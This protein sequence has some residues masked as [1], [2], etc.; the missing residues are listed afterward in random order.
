[1]SKNRKLSTIKS[2]AIALPIVAALLCFAFWLPGD[3][4]ATR[5]AASVTERIASL[6]YKAGWRYEFAVGIR[7]GTY[8]EGQELDAE[9]LFDVTTLNSELDDELSKESANKVELK[10][11]SG[12]LISLRARRL[13][14]ETVAEY[15]NQLSAAKENRGHVLA[16]ILHAKDALHKPP[17]ASEVG[18][19]ADVEFYKSQ[20]LYLEQYKKLTGHACPEATAY[21][22]AQR[23]F[24]QARADF[25]LADSMDA[26]AGR[27]RSLNDEMQKQ[28]GIMKAASHYFNLDTLLLQ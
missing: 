1:M 2:A 9:Y 18:Y 26:G 28:L 16:A 13:L 10:A 15:D 22:T 25:Y 3:L 17:V 11:L 27:L 7:N 5:D 20:L 24:A 8:S 6:N 21:Y 12:Q 4:S 19:R 23:D 14:Q